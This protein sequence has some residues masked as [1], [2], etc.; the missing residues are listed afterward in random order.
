MDINGK[1]TGYYEYGSGYELPFF[2]SKIEIE[3]EFIVDNKN[4]VT[5]TI[6][7]TPSQFSIPEKAKI[8]GFI[9]RG[10]ISFLKKYDVYP[11]INENNDG[12][13]ITEGKF[14]IPHTGYIHEE[15]NSIYGVWDIE[16]PYEEDGQTHMDYLS[17]IWLLKRK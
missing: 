10:L 3:V 2:A 14:E 15:Y 17:G 13:I 8:T 6:I 4:K 1:W 16:C 9:D 7:E 12:I 5:G 11:Q